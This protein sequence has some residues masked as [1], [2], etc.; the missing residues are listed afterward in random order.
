MP[1]SG[2]CSAIRR[3]SFTSSSSSRYIPGTLGR[4]RH[5]SS[6]PRES[7][8]GCL[9]II[10]NRIRSATEEDFTRNATNFSLYRILSPL[11]AA[12]RTSIQNKVLNALVSNSALV[13]DD[14]LSKVMPIREC[15]SSSPALESGFVCYFRSWQLSNAELIQVIQHLKQEGFH[16]SLLASLSRNIFD[17]IENRDITIRYAGVTEAPYTPWTRTHKEVQRHKSLKGAFL[18]ALQRLFGSD[19]A[20]G[21]IFTL[22]MTFTEDL[23]AQSQFDQPRTSQLSPLINEMERAVIALFGFSSLL[24]RQTGGKQLPISVSLESECAFHACRTSISRSL[25]LSSFKKETSAAP[26]LESV[27]QGWHRSLNKAN[28]FAQ[29]YQQAANMS[30]SQAIPTTINGVNLLAI[31]AEQLPKKTI[32]DATPFFSGSRP[33]AQC[34]IDFI[35][36]LLY[37]EVSSQDRTA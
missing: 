32:L 11:E 21:K 30:V 28:G 15:Y 8:P 12:A 24:N 2:F 14:L 31:C 10:K 34:T 33:A 29:Y 7:T 13:T 27:V 19:T 6:T 26:I 5:S 1:S 9:Y 37:L 20:S 16:P 23:C 17:G 4:R 3:A 18:T 22:P 36:S 25:L 35:Q